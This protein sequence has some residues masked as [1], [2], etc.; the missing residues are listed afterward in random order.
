[1]AGGEAGIAVTNDPDLFD[2][3]VLLG[4]IGRSRSGV[5]GRF[6]IDDAELGVTDLGVKY[7][8]HPFAIHLARS[9]L[10]RL[11]AENARRAKLW[12]RI[13]HELSGSSCLAPVAGLP[14]AQRGGYYSF[15]VEYRGDRDGPHVEQIVQR[16]RSRGVPVEIEPYGR[17]LLHRSPTFTSLDRR[18]LG[19]GCF[20][21]TRSWDENLSREALPVC[22]DAAPR[23]LA[24]DRMMCAAGETFVAWSAREL[25]RA[26]EESQ[27]RRQQDIAPIEELTAPGTI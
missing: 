9:S 3:M 2:R 4:Q 20:D 21:A 22:E 19:G 5:H 18:R 7:R 16:A 23:L 6:G 12:S 25:R 10:K 1:V 26:A 27:S 13:E 15:V 17:H 8:P 14:K 24:F 11:P